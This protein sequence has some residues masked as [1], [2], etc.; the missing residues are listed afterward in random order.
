MNELLN[1]AGDFLEPERVFRELTADEAIF[2]L[3]GAPHSIAQIGAHS[4]YWQIVMLRQLMAI[5]NAE[6]GDDEDYF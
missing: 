5:W 3:P 2:K 4:N 1:G 6:P